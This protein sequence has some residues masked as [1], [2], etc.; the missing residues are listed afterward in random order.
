MAFVLCAK[1]PIT[2]KNRLT[3]RPPAYRDSCC[4]NYWFRA[5]WGRRTTI[6]VFGTGTGYSSISD[7][8][9][10]TSA[11]LDFHSIST[12]EIFDTM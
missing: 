10:D 5:G 4:N 1:S 9:I 8:T 3:Y 6:R 2:K 11:L 12:P 7:C